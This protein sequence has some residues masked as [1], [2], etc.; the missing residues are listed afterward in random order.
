LHARNGILV[1]LGILLCGRWLRLTLCGVF[2]G[3]E[4]NWCF[5]NCEQM[6]VELKEFSSTS[7]CCVLGLRL[8]A[9][10]INCV[11]LKKKKKVMMCFFFKLGM[12]LVD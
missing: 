12:K 3:K 7:W 8:F 5:E 11:Y 9:F 2:G 4:M 10:L 1:G 6:V